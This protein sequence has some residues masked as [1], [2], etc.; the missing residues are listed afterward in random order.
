MF[1]ATKH[2]VSGYRVSGLTNMVIDS[3]VVSRLDGRELE[4]S[5]RTNECPSYLTPTFTVQNRPADRTFFSLHPASSVA[6]FVLR[7]EKVFLLKVKANLQ[8]FAIFLKSEMCKV[9]VLPILFL[10]AVF[11]EDLVHNPIQYHSQTPRGSYN[12]G[13]DTGLYGSHS[14]HQENRNANGQVRGRYGYTDPDGNLRL[15]YYTA[16]PQGFNVIKDTPAPASAPVPVPVYRTH[17]DVTH[18]DDRP[19]I[20]VSSHSRPV[21]APCKY[22]DPPC[23]QKSK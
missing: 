11:A 23:T 14:F 12:Y 13:Y 8:F 19:V 20:E 9:L 4:S 15:T 18:H 16:G 22:R 5:L 3:L 7:S 21:S 6:E 1:S 17:S 2:K 10:T